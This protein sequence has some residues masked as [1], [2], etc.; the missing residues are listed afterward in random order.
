MVRHRPGRDMDILPRRHSGKALNNIM[1][2][3]IDIML[4]SDGAGEQRMRRVS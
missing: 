1:T 3:P 4:G 2:Q